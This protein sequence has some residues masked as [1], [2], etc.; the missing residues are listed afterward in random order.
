MHH[1]M[2]SIE[3]DVR[4]LDEALASSPLD[5]LGPGITLQQKDSLIRLLEEDKHVKGRYNTEYSLLSDKLKNIT[6]KQKSF[7]WHLVMSQK[8][9]KLDEI[10]QQL[11]IPK[12][13][14][15]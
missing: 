12:I 11:Q 5:Q 2:Q 6:Q 15:T 10:L 8:Y 7:I 9:H 1:I 3:A 13:W 4:R 14:N